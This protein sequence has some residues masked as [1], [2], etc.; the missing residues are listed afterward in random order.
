MDEYHR[1][2]GAFTKAKAEYTF[3]V[4]RDRDSRMTQTAKMV[5][6]A[7]LEHLNFDNGRC[8][9]SHRLLADKLGIGLRTVDRIMPT[10]AAV[11]WISTKRRGATTT[12]LYRFQVEAK[13]VHGILDYDDYL[14]DRRAEER[15]ERKAVQRSHELP[16]VADHPPTEPPLVAVHEPPSVRSHELPL[17]AD[18]PLKRTPEVEPLK[19]EDGSEGEG[20]ALRAHTREESAYDPAATLDA[21]KRFLQAIGCPA[22]RTDAGLQ[23]L[24]RGALYPANIAEWQREEVEVRDAPAA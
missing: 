8:D 17:V 21:G 20:Y 16:L 23:R 13:K 5:L 6:L 1:L 14:R 24:M 19:P 7:L 2:H 9:P 12:N 4:M 22:H 11:G 18:K 10:L 15:A 3:Y